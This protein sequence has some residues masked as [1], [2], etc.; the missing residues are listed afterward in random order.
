MLSFA[1]QLNNPPRIHSRSLYIVPYP[2][3][4]GQRF[5]L[6][7]RTSFRRPCTNPEFFHRVPSPAL[8][9]YPHLLPPA[10]GDGTQRRVHGWGDHSSQ[11]SHVTHRFHVLC[12]WGLLAAGRL[13]NALRLRAPGGDNG[14]RGHSTFL[15]AMS[16]TSRLSVFFKP[17]LSRYHMPSAVLR[18]RQRGD[19]AAAWPW[20]SR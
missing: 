17:F 7:R 12:C 9:C 3:P 5:R 8:G 16:N 10:R 14:S 13:G 6:E 11:V 4:A 2:G 1:E 18:A 15:D 19:R 20:R